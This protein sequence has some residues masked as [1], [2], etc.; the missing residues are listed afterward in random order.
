MRCLPGLIENREESRRLLPPSLPTRRTPS[1]V[2][3]RRFYRETL[4]ML[5]GKRRALTLGAEH[6][7]AFISITNPSLQSVP[8]YCE[9]Y[10]LHNCRPRESEGCNER[11]NSDRVVACFKSMLFC[12]F[13]STSEVQIIDHFQPM[14]HRFVCVIRYI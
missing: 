3:V 1:A 6:F 9:E 10:F 11:R 4:K 14:R 13:F 12:C 7:I 5:G 2:R 8:K